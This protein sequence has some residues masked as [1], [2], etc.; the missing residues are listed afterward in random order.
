[1]K[2]Q[3]ILLAILFFSINILN[4]MDSQ[5]RKNLIINECNE[6]EITDPFDEIEI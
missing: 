2:K 6:V 4:S 5:N 3:S 1:M